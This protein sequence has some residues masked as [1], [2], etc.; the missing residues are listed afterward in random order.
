MVWKGGM[1]MLYAASGSCFSDTKVIRGTV[2]DNV[3][4][5]KEFIG[6]TSH[7]DFWNAL[8]LLAEHEQKFI[9]LRY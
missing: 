9:E 5:S 8:R 1:N 6:S 4:N 3:F 2:K 7:P